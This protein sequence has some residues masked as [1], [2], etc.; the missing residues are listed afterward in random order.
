MTDA[1]IYW[2]RQDLRVQDLPGL[3]AAA[4]TGKPLVACYIL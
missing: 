2:F 4:A 3:L 1:I